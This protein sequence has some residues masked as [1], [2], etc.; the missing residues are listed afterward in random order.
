MVTPALERI[1]EANTLLSGLGFES[2]VSW[3]LRRAL[4][5]FALL[6]YAALCLLVDLQATPLMCS[7]ACSWALLS[8][9]PRG[10]WSASGCIPLPRSPYLAGPVCGAF[11]A[12]WADQGARHACH[13]AWREGARGQAT[14]LALAAYTSAT[15]TRIKTGRFEDIMTQC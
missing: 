6:C 7:W 2:A 3:V 5:C 11:R 14:W 4:L 13:A 12:Q 9:A 10:S 1:V 8:P 15:K